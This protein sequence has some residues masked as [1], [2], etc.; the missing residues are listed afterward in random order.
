M[1]RKSTKLNNSFKLRPFNDDD[2]EGLANLKKTI[3]PQHPI[4]VETMRHNDKTRDVKILHQQWVWE[5]RQSIL[6]SI[7]YTQ[8]EEIYHP[9]K[10]VIKIYVHPNYQRLG[11]GTI[12]YD[13]LLDDLKQ[14]DPIKLTTQVHEPHQQSIHFLEKRGFKNT[15]T[16]RESI[17]DLTAYNPAKYED[18]I[19]RIDQH[20]FR[21][22]TLSDFR[23]EDKKADFKVWE[24]E[25]EVS[26]DMP[27]P[28]PISI[29]EFDHYQ[30]YILKHPR[31]NP[32]SW[33]LVLKGNL[34]A[35][36]N[37][38]WK[39]PDKK[40]VTT[41][42]TG[43]RRKYRRKGIATALKH[44]CLTWAKEQGYKW[45]RTNNADSNEG[46]LSINF[47]VGFKFIPAWLVYDKVIKE[48]E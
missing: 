26:P 6:C 3:Y 7:L 48:E 47:R 10:F 19:T 27:W 5:H 38:L 12:C 22:I 43:V 41:G 39:T 20:G 24:F 14:Y 30:D 33:F 28:D 46:M 34:L 8:W 17:L 23:K 9:Q 13:H 42:L 45:I 4:S 31:F 44:T 40:V 15:A 16:E 18:E 37:N 2:Y 32:D 21:L 1:N 35:G 25:R 11:Y 36:L 29:P